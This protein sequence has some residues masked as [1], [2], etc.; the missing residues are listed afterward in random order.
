ML[1]G[2]DEK[3]GRKENGQNYLLNRSDLHFFRSLDR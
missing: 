2:R 3:K 1:F